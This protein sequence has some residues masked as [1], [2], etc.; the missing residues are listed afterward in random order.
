MSC[1]FTWCRW[2]RLLA[3]VTL[4]LF[5]GSP[6]VGLAQQEATNRQMLPV[7][8]PKVVPITE[9]D[10]RKAT[11]PT[12]FEVRAP[13]G[14]PNVVIVLIDDMG[15]GQPSAFGG[16]VNMPT[17]DRLARNGLRY[18]RFHTTA[19]CAPT[20][21]ALLTGRNH[22]SCNMGSVTETATAFPGQ[23][24]V[25]PQNIAPL[26]EVLRLNGYST[27]QFGK[28]HET[29]P[30]EISP[31]G[32]FDRWP[33][34]SGFDK[35][36]GFMGG[37][38][39]QYYPGIYDGVA[40]VSPPSDPN[41]HFTTDMTNQAIAWAQYQQALTPNKPFFIYYAPGATHAPHQAP[42][43]Y[44]E[45]YR[46]KFDHGWDKQREITL[47]NQKKI[48]VVPQNTQLAAKPEA[49]KDWDTLTD[50][51]QR[52]FARQ[53]EVFAGF[54]E[55]TDHEVGRLVSAIEEMGQLDNTLFIYILG[56][57][58]ASAEGGMVG[59]FNEMNYFNQV[60]EKLQDILKRID[61]LGSRTAYNHYSAGW[62]VA[63]DT[64]FTWTKQVAS[65]FGGT[66]NG[67]IV[68]WPKGIKAKNALRSQF[69][70]VID[71]APTVLQACSLPEPKLVNGF[72]QHPIEGV[73]MNY[74]FDD[75]QANERHITQ[76]FEIFC[77]RAIYHDGWVAGT[78][79]KA[80]WEAKPRVESFDQNRWELYNVTEDFS[81]STD[82]AG[83]HPDKLKE[84]QELFLEQAAEYQVLPLDGRLFERFNAAMVGRPD[85]IGD[86]SAL[87]MY[88]GMTG[89]MDN[90][91]INVKNRSHAITAEL[92]VS[93]E[94]T[95]GVILC[96][97]GRFGG[98]S[99]YAK[100]GRL[101]YCYNW[102]GLEHYQLTAE[103]PL[104][105]GRVRVEFDF[106]YDGDGLGKGGNA[107]LLV[108][109]DKVA[110]G[111]IEH[112][113][114][115]I[116]SPDETADVGRD[117]ATTVTDDYEEADNSFSGQIHKVT[118]TLKRQ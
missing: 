57:N 99:L 67:M 28:N 71:V 85:L 93:A 1:L 106:E 60:P 104:P 3:L 47:A 56:D 19:L 113:A 61:E 4:I 86:R 114:G 77:N 34:R 81:Q 66:R 89:M 24:A 116:F 32:P 92:E 97:G 36:Y 10:A 109:G 9:I 37:E 112:T 2:L 52:L 7:V 5:T 21:M 50:D 23:T 78:V 100:G 103:K 49:I 44:I 31:S 63:G 11:A 72:E 20:R 14:A 75:A 82:L 110:E 79:H 91:F 27:A 84:L 102:V 73:S 59:L 96:Q 33:T 29:P 107:T 98:W 54:G 26:A 68:H 108:N 65:S 80:P 118:V 43:E 90:V 18:N 51:E 30:W 117:E 40:R 17:A 38:T 16:P 45:K 22:H 15:F 70:H 35:F 58:G 6:L 94:P 88:A 111:R 101:N 115:V 39:N 62:A 13:H 25:R 105:T 12:R 64:P 76:Y 8:E 55:H 53:M 41:Y 69:H 46:G 42:R 74:S 87:T 83:K 95:E 48:G